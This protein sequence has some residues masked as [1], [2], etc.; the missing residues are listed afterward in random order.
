MPAG[1]AARGILGESAKT[2]TAREVLHHLID[3]LPPAEVET[4]RRFLEFLCLAGPSEESVSSDELAASDAAWRDYTEGRDPG[5]SL[6]KVRKEL[7][8]IG[9][10]GD[11]YKK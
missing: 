2:M 9:P 6:E 7:L 3:E 11:V 4:A 5:E 10:R 8:H 1:L